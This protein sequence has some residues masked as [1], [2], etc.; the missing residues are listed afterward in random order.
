VG[1]DADA[2]LLYGYDLGGD[3]LWKIEGLAPYDS[4]LPGWLPPSVAE[5]LLDDEGIENVIEHR[6]IEVVAGFTDSAPVTAFDVEPDPWRAYW[7]R[8]DTA[9]RR[10]QVELIAH[11][12]V[13]GDQSYVLAFRESRRSTEAG[14]VLALPSY[15]ELMLIERRARPH[16]QQALEALDVRPTEEA[17]WLIVASY[18]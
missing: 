14:G 10:V 11:G 12:Y 8:Y 17:R 15:D 7:K 4:W 1:L 5:R 18:G 9:A 2:E 13:E 6:L 3:G 16:L